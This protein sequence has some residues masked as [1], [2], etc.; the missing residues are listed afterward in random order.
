MEAQLERLE[1]DR[2]R[3]TVEVPPGEVHHAVEHATH[4]L[5]GRVKVPGFRAGKVPEQVLVSRIGK[6]RVYTEAVESHIGGWFRSAA[7]TRR[8]RPAEPPSFD[9]ELPTTAERSWT[10]TAEFPVQPAVEPADW[11]EL[12]VP[13]MEVTVREDDELVE[14]ELSVL[15]EIS[16]PLAPV[17][18]RPAR[19]GDVAVVDII[20]RDGTGQRDYVVELGTRRLVGEIEAGILNLE[21]GRDRQVSWERGD[22]ATQTATVTLK[23]LHEKVLPP[24]DDQVARAA[25][26]FDTL[27]ELR[28]D[29]VRR[30]TELLE[31]EAESQ[32]RLRA[33]DA[34]IRASDVAPAPLAV[35]WRTEELIT[36]FLR[37]LD[38]QGIDPAAYLRMMGVT[39]EQLERRFWEE[40]A[41]SIARE[42]VLEGVADKL[43]I[44]VTDDDIRSDLL[45]EGEDEEEID[46][47]IAAGG[48]DRVRQDLRLRRAVDRIVAEVKPISPELAEAR[49]SIWTPGK[50]QGASPEKT[51]W[52]PGSVDKE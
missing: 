23:E 24:L 6:Q 46:E 1:G 5:A 30:V 41:G 39:G 31:R 14:A 2:V 25:S 28:A 51:L 33:V 37:Q 8:V 10:F 34:L 12:E 27:D 16:A 45:D 4:D 17:E 40:A 48:A 50:E 47:F 36:A 44:E 19:P 22:D 3:L 42:L 43:E 18:G 21:P 13:R 26:E 11:T 49:E 20:S 15:Q 29:I 9:Y 52:V 38:A 7:R 35:E 32:F